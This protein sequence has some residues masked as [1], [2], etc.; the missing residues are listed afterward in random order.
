MGGVLQGDAVSLRTLAEM[1]QNP[2]GTGKLPGANDGDDDTLDASGAGAATPG[3]EKKWD[4]HTQRNRG[5]R[6][7]E[8]KIA[9]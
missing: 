8:S 1:L 3:E 4:L 5:K 7:F 6:E 9:K 2:K